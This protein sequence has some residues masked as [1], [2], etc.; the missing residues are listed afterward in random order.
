MHIAAKRVTDIRASFPQSIF[1]K[2][3]QEFL[4]A[5]YDPIHVLPPLPADI[6]TRNVW[7]QVTDLNRDTV[8]STGVSP[9]G[10]Y[11]I[12]TDTFLNNL[13]EDPNA[14]KNIT[15]QEGDERLSVVIGLYSYD[16]ASGFVAAGK[17]RAHI[18]LFWKSLSQALTGIWVVGMFG[19]FI[20]NRIS[21]KP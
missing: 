8:V 11:A 5:G 13:K 4:S 20:A 6:R 7:M 1:V 21:K 18:D 16:L 17:N 3:A 12:P 15:V 9:D 19:F 14:T 10:I 2:Q